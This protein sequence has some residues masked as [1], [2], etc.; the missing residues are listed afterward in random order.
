[1]GIRARQLKMV[2][3]VQKTYPMV[4]KE[5]GHSLKA[6]SS[7]CPQKYSPLGPYFL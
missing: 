4:R 1:M 6:L 7:N 3:K 2:F 5:G